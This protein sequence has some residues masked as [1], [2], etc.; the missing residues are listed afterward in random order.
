MRLLKW[1]LERVELL[2]EALNELFREWREGAYIVVEGRRDKEALKDLGL[3]TNVIAFKTLNCN[4]SDA[5]GK[6]CREGRVVILTDFD[7]EGEEL[8]YRMSEILSKRGVK[9]NLEVRRKLLHI[10]RGEIK[11]FQ[12]LSPLLDRLSTRFK[13]PLLQFALD[14]SSV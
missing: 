13:M 3:N 8:A 6:L 1:T 5:I 4:M 12:D 7:R 11:G 9:V 10:L 14:K 2:M